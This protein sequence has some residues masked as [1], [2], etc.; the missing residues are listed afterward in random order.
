MRNVKAHWPRMVFCFAEE[1]DGT[2][3]AFC[4][5]FDLAVQGRSFD[6]V[7]SK[8]NEQLHL[9]VGYISE[10]PET[11]QKRFLRRRA[12]VHVTALILC[13]VV[14]SVL[15]RGLRSSRHEYSLPIER[16]ASA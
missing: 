16:F 13:K 6:E 3:E 14:G 9:Y 15:F 2:W 1:Q 8:L 11:D 10:L 4:V 5:D 7:Y 12:P